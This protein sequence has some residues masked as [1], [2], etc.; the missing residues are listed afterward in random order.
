MIN[1]DL[2]DLSR[3][4]WHEAGHVLMTTVLLGRIER[5]TIVPCEEAGGRTT[6]RAGSSTPELIASLMRS[7]DPMNRWAAT[8]QAADLIHILI[9]GQ[10]GEWVLAGRHRLYPA[11]DIDRIYEVADII[12]AS[13]ARSG[14]RRGY[15]TFVIRPAFK[16][17]RRWLTEHRAQMSAVADALLEHRTL[18]VKE[19]EDVL[20]A[21]P[22]LRRPRWACPPP[23]P[24]PGITLVVTA[25]RAVR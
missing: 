3:A 8:A 1:Q 10:A 2:D 17:V 12:Y 5:V 22:E 13:S 4:A 20:G 19:V 16:R 25:D 18:D 23:P 21:H 14:D 24:A 7:N 15:N 9:A 11:G 6:L